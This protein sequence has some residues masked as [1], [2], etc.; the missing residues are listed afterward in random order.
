MR[1]KPQRAQRAPHISVH[2]IPRKDLRRLPVHPGQVDEAEPAG[3]PAEE[4]V[5]RHAHQRD[6]V[7]FLIDGGDAGLLGLLGLVEFHRPPGIDNLALVGSIHPGQHLDEG[8]LA[9]TVLTD[10]SVH[11][12]GLDLKAHVVQGQHAREAF[13]HP[14]DAQQWHAVHQ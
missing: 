5:A 4:Q 9:R 8:R 13:A 6:Q 1:A 10:Q 11:L 12:P 7:D 3:L 2:A 14:P